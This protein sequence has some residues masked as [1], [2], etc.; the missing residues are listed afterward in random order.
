MIVQFF[1]HLLPA[2]LGEYRKRKIIGFTLC[3]VF[4]AGAIRHVDE[5]TEI[6]FWWE[7]NL[8]DWGPCWLK[9]EIK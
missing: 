7:N 6:Q 8:S 5:E 1:F 2:A 4:R 3:R 9:K